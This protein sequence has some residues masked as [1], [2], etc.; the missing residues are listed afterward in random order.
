MEENLLSKTVKDLREMAR[1]LGIP[2]Y[3]ALKK[4][5]LVSAIS[6]IIEK[7]KPVAKPNPQPVIQPVVSQPVVKPAPEVKRKNVLVLHLKDESEPSFE[8]T[9][10]YCSIDRKLIFKVTYHPVEYE[11][12]Y[13]YKKLSRDMDAVCIY[14][15]DETTVKA[16]LRDNKTFRNASLYYDS[17]MLYRTYK[18]VIDSNRLQEEGVT[19]LKV[20]NIV[21]SWHSFRL[22]L[23]PNRVYNKTQYYSSLKRNA[24]Y[25]IIKFDEQKFVASGGI[26]TETPENVGAKNLLLEC[27]HWF[28]RFITRIQDCSN[29]RLLQISGTCYLNA[30]INGLFLTPATRLYLTDVFNREPKIFKQN[31]VSLSCP[32]KDS[33]TSKDFIMKLFYH[34]ICKSET[35]KEN[36]DI[37]LQSSGKFFSSNNDSS[38]KEEFGQGGVS[39]RTLIRIL[40]SLDIDFGYTSKELVFRIGKMNL[41]VQLGEQIEFVKRLSHKDVMPEILI[42]KQLLAEKELAKEIVV[43]FG[44]MYTLQFAI[45]EFYWNDESGVEPSHAVV[46]IFCDGHPFVFDSNSKMVYANWLNPMELKTD[47]QPLID[48]YTNLA[49]KCYVSY[50][51]YMRQD[52]YERLLA[53]PPTCNLANAVEEDF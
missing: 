44:I 22:G 9:G 38:N 15:K 31:L 33:Y 35:L 6:A 41:Q 39:L 7:S 13:D 43:Q 48:M 8:V 12:P 23:Y 46:G 19:G 40:Q 20:Y 28:E 45:I 30:V 18:Y 47:M 49:T 27:Q 26:A 52:I 42:F 37:L 25:R 53:N 34:L 5:E 51:L 36:Y 4:T 21:N 32:T 50:A 2:K 14:C 24:L 16:F 3:Y 17:G 10:K 29:G 1:T 11:T